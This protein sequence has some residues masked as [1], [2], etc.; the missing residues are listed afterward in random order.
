M[1]Y[2][3]YKEKTKERCLKIL[4]VMSQ[5]P[6]FQYLI[7]NMLDETRKGAEDNCVEMP[8]DDVNLPAE[9]GVA[10]AFRQLIM[11]CRNSREV[12]EKMSKTKPKTPT[13]RPR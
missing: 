12:L 1:K 3:R 7:E 10:R 6:D 11:I 13:A 4:S 9:Q 5:D 8:H 2:I